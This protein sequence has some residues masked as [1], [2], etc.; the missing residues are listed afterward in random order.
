MAVLPDLEEQPSVAP[1]D[2]V[3]VA[4]VVGVPTSRAVLMLHVI[5]T[6]LLWCLAWTAS[7]TGD[8]GQMEARVGAVPRGTHQLSV[9]PG[10]GAMATT[11]G[12]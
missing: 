10:P 9:Q 11:Q 5:F 8:A 12:G 7:R 1:V 4:L 3:T 2:A 6:C